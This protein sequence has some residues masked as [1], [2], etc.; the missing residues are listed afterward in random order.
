[1]INLAYRPS[2]LSWI[3]PIIGLG[4]GGGY[5][6][7]AGSD[8]F[9]NAFLGDAIGGTST[10]SPIPALQIYTGFEAKLTDR[11]FVSVTPRLLWVGAAPFGDGPRYTDF[12]LGTNVGYRF[13]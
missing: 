2:G 9:R 5:G 12:I 4:V 10:R 7:A 1:M 11:F 13:R 6:S 3:R 8:A